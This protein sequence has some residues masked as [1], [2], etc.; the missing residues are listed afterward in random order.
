MSIRACDVVELS[1][2]SQAGR[3]RARWAAAGVEFSA[4]CVIHRPG[5]L[6]A[7][8]STDRVLGSLGVGGA[9]KGGRH[10]LKEA[11]WLP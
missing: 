2:V 4:R 7:R 10:V 5:G 9:W 1:R 6:R 8:L 3:T 11:P